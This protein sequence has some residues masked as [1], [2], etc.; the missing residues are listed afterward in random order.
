LVLVGLVLVLVYNL[1]TVQFLCSLLFVLLVEAQGAAWALTLALVVLV[2]EQAPPE[3]LGL[4]EL[5]HKD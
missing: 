3:Q 2:V 1:A 5:S 4:L